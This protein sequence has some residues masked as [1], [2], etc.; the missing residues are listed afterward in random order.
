MRRAITLFALSL[1]LVQGC[2]SSPTTPPI[3]PLA[4]SMGQQPVV[5]NPQPVKPVTPPTPV[6]PPPPSPIPAPSPIATTRPLERFTSEQVVAR[7]S[8]RPITLAQLYPVLIEGYGLNLMMNVVQLEYAKQQA[9]RAGITVSPEDIQ[10][11]RERTF[12]QRFPDADKSDHEMLFAQYL[13][14]QHVA[15]AEVEIGFETNTYLRKL[16]E[17]LVKD[18]ITDVALEAAFREMYGETVLIR[19]IQ[20]ANMQEIL[21]AKRR[22]AAGEP[23]EKVAQEV[24]RNARTSQLGGELPTFSRQSSD[25][26]QNFKEAAFALKEGEV[27]EAVSAY[28]AFHLLK[29]EKRFAPRAIKFEDVKESLREDI[30]ERAVDSVMKQ[31]RTQYLQEALAVLIVDQPV[32]KKQLDDKLRQRD[33][34]ITDKNEIKE[35]FERERQKILERAATQESTTQPVPRTAP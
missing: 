35:Q 18:K 1:A 14:Q 9:E 31:I 13:Q 25:Y 32:L 8:G 6:N 24:S 26:P 30:T 4:N 10:R 19:H 15:R 33:S 34:Q 20:A 27:S 11:E 17:P 21:E 23:F 16:A 29:L 12:A 3:E 22:L 2:E 28:G 7:L 5:T